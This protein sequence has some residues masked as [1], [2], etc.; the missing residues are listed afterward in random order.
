MVVGSD[1]G[2]EV[3]PGLPRHPQ[4]AA[5]G[6]PA[7]SSRGRGAVDRLSHQ[8]QA[9]AAAQTAT[10]GSASESAPG[11]TAVTRTTIASAAI[12]LAAISRKKVRAPPQVAGGRSP[13]T[14]AVSHSRRC[15]A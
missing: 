6:P 3:S 2:L 14:A 1:E 11:R 4:Q 9:G 7:V 8:A 15:A 12:G 10:K 13:C 5:A